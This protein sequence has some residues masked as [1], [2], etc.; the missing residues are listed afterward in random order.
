MKKLDHNNLFQLLDFIVDE[1]TCLFI[2]E[3]KLD[4]L[5]AWIAGYIVASDNINIEKLNEFSKFVHIKF[6]VKYVNTIGWY[7]SI[8]GIYD[9]D[10]TGFNIFC[11]L[12]KEFRNKINLND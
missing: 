1:Q 12:Y 6:N 9:G 4:L 11:D 5:Y 7:G 2:V 10:E 8:R 3:P